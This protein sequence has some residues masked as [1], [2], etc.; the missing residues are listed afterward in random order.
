MG[1]VCERCERA[2]SDTMITTNDVFGCE[3]CGKMVGECCL[4]EVP[5]G[6]VAEFPVCVD[7]QR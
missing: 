5:D 7:C 1:P 2:T 6:E 3:H 4:A